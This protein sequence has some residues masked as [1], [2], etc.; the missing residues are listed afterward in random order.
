MFA[1]QADKTGCAKF[2]TKMSLFTNI[3]AK[4]FQTSLY[5][6]ASVQEEG[7]GKFYPRSTALGAGW[8]AVTRVLFLT[9]TSFSKD[10]LVEL[11]YVI[12]SLIFVDTPKIYNEGSM[13]EGKVGA[14]DDR[15]GCQRLEA[16][17]IVW[18]APCLAAGR[19]KWS[20]TTTRPSPTSRSSC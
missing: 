10:K 17:V 8:V 7:T 2:F 15:Q 12:G 16:L 9:G 6:T 5:I 20:T 13:L 1:V 14:R 18:D 11:S 4:A 19:S 3:E